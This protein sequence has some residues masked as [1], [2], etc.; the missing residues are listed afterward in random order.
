MSFPAFS[1]KGGEAG[2]RGPRAGRQAAGGPVE[3]AVLAGR[4]GALLGRGRSPATFGP[5]QAALAVGRALRRDLRRALRLALGLL[6][7]GAWRAELGAGRAE[8][9][10]QRG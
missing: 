9:R 5:E 4:V 7:Q 1:H 2:D 6:G 3:G 8:L 10:G